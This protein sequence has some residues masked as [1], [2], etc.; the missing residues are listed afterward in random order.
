LGTEASNNEQT[1]P[2]M[3]DIFMLS[4]KLKELSAVADEAKAGERY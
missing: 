1:P 3:A 2:M 4:V